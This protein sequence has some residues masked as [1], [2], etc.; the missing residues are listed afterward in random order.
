MGELLELGTSPPD[1]VMHNV[2]WWVWLQ[3]VL[4]VAQEGPSLLPFGE[5][6]LKVELEVEDAGATLVQEEDAAV[7]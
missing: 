5:E 3:S 2:G 6:E 4:L 1:I 7:G